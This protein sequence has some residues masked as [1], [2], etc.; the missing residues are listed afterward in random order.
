MPHVTLRCT[1][2]DNGFCQARGRDLTLA[3]CRKL[4][5]CDEDERECRD[6]RI[7]DVQIVRKKRKA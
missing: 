4:F 1:M 2:Q 5:E 6:C 7:L 3:E